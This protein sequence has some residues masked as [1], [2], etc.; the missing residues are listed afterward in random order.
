MPRRLITHSGTAGLMSD[1]WLAAG[2]APTWSSW[3]RMVFSVEMILRVAIIGKKVP[4]DGGWRGMGWE[5]VDGRES[6]WSL[7]KLLQLAV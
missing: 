2:L 6:V 3:S 4:Q 5:V 1:F 7:M